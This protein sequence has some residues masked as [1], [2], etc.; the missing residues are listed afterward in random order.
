MPATLK[1]AARPEGA[2]PR[3][4][5]G[6]EGGFRGGDRGDRDS[7]R[8]EGGAGR[9]FGGE[10]KVGPGGDYKPEYRGGQLPLS[11]FFVSPRDLWSPLSGVPS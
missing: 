4:P 3:A 1:R 11:L 5:A 9:G 2:A 7:Y 10:K 8:R 6:R